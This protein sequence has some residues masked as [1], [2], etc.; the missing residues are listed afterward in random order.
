M[1]ISRI[2][3]PQPLHTGESLSLEPQASRHLSQVLRLRE[4]AELHLFNGNGDAFCATITSANKKGVELSIGEKLE[5]SSKESPLETKLG[6][7]ISKGD[8][9]DWLIQKCTELGVSEIIPLLSERVDV[10]LP[11]D[12]MAKKL[13]HWQQVAISACEQSG[14]NQVP[15]ILQPQKLEN[16]VTTVSA[17]KK[18]VLDF[19][20]DDKATSEDA[21]NSIA[22]L[23]G[24][25]GGLSELEVQA[26]VQSGF[27]RWRLGQRVMRTETAPV[28]A[29]SVLQYLYGDF[30]R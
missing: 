3:T 2:Y 14:R 17:N 25:E 26:A 13:Q 10:K 28:A 16:W 21:S 29:L 1:R 27:Y 22:L 7:G 15:A 19:E 24:P 4:G 20:N 9:M 5:H 30:E 12:R 8:R 18:L 23:V 11:A 6:I